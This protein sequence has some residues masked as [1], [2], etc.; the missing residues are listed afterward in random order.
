MPSDQVI[1]IRPD[2]PPKPPEGRPC[3]GC[4]VCCLSEPCPAGVLASRR[5][6][7]ACAALSWSPAE[8]RYRCGLISAPADWLPPLLR[9][10]APLL[11]RLA[12]RFVAAGRGCDSS[13][14]VERVP[15]G[16]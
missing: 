16:G 12:R 11:A 4:G 13:V 1:L 10:A 7:G 3:N 5:L 14:V 9:G 15:G 8:A 6:R 2:A